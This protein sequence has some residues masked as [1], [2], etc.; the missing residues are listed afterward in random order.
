MIQLKPIPTLFLLLLSVHS[1]AQS[2]FL[3][4]ERDYLHLVDRMD[5]RSGENS[6]FG[7]TGIKPFLRKT[8][9]QQSQKIGQTVL[10]NSLSDSFNLV[11][12]SKDNPEW[13]SKQ[14]SVQNPGLFGKFYR[15]PNALYR[16]EIEDGAFQINPVLHFQ[17]SGPATNYLGFVNQ[18]GLEVRG[19]VGGKI[20]FYSAIT[21][22][23]MA[24]TDAAEAFD[25]SAPGIGFRKNYIPSSKQINP[26]GMPIGLDFFLAR[27]YL[28]WSPIKQVQ[29]Q[30][31]ND[32]NFIGN[33][34]ETFILSDFSPDILSLKAHTKLWKFNYLNLFS[35]LND[36]DR[37]SGMGGGFR[38]KY[39]AL[40]YLGFDVLKNLSIGIFEQVIFSR[41]SSQAQG[42]KLAYLNPVIFYR[43]VEH[44]QNSADNILVGMDWK[45]NFLQK[46]SFYG[47]FV[48]DEFKKDEMF[49]GNGWWAN[50]W[51]FQ[52]GIKCIDLWGLENLDVQAEFNTA[53]PF[54]F[55]H[56]NP[57]QN[58][59]HFTQALGH[60]SGANFRE[61]RC[62][63]RYQPRPRW[64]AELFILNRLK[65]YDQ[66]EGQNFGG[67][68]NK[69][70]NFRSTSDYNNRILQGELGHDLIFACNMTYMPA[71]NLFFDLGSRYQNGNQIE[72][73]I[74]FYAG[75]RL[76][77]ATMRYNRY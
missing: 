28:S 19:H 77:A 69:A 46:F 43:A 61:L 58:Y 75:M 40:H 41:D 29:L 42:Y 18:R 12:I 59:S 39:S 56:F 55:Q 24:F 52:A 34:M 37:F 23:Q 14:G 22:N 62:L 71:H 11:Y 47:Q 8:I 33:G 4:L 64:R 17:M 35:E 5:I 67:D 45:W 36:L 50:K 74:F 38:P 10:S 49:S 2:V 73:A 57:S 72:P 1:N 53:R 13:T 31:G 66:Q 30:F 21:E 68:L 48:L 6:L 26:N 25:S 7:Y 44:N 20:G 15:S 32:R 16:P 9:A 65:G 63:M 70:Y 76:N 51:A 54:T 60:P 3:P 27:G